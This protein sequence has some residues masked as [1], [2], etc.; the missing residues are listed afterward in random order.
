MLEEIR[1]RTGEEASMRCY[2]HPVWPDW[3]IYWILRNFFKP[4][5][6]NYLPKSPTLLGN[7][8]K[9]SKSIIFV[10]KQF[11]GNFYRHLANFFWS[12]C[13]IPTACRAPTCCLLTATWGNQVR[14]KGWTST[15]MVSGSSVE[16]FCVVYGNLAV[17]YGLIPLYV[18]ICG[19][20]KF[21][22]IG[23]GWHEHN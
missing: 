16:F 4:F 1:R 21:Y 3:A 15:C 2:T 17:I 12:H 9:V 14:G 10:A 6:N 8:V 18:N 11:L 13:P 23:P 22:G 5:G 19:Q 20:V 7:F